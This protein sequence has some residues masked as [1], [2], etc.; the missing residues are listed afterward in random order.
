MMKL[1]KLRRFFEKNLKIKTYF[2]EF[3]RT[4]FILLV[5]IY[6]Y[7]LKRNLLVFNQ[8]EMTKILGSMLPELTNKEF[9]I[10]Y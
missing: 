3:P 5:R 1:Q 6:F 8:V 9:E 2:L 7:S 4:H 10:V